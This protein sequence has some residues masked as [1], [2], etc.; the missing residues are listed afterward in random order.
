MANFAVK[1]AILLELKEGLHRKKLGSGF[2]RLHSVGEEIL[3][4]PTLEQS[5]IDSS[6][7]KVYG[8]LGCTVRLCK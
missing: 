7:H 8:F 3:S 1:S 6:N 4:E 5:G 2:E